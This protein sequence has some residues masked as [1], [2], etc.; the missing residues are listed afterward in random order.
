MGL[1]PGR[2]ICL[3]L[4]PGQSVDAKRCSHYCFDHK[5]I[6]DRLERLCTEDLVSSHSVFLGAAAAAAAVVVDNAADC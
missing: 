4:S 2:V 1:T 5:M 6:D 3:E